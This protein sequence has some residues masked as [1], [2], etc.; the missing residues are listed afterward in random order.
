M[1]CCECDADMTAEVKAACSSG[2]PHPTKTE[3]I[4]MLERQLDRV[5]EDSPPKAVTLQCPQGHWCSY[6]CG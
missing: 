5:D 1:K 6:P 2:G 4:P 3:M